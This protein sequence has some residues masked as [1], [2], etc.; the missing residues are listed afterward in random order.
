MAENNDE[1]PTEV[2]A[3]TPRRSSD[4]Y[5]GLLMLVLVAVAA[6]GFGAGLAVGSS[7]GAEPDTFAHELADWS[8]CVAA[9]GAAVPV[10]EAHRDGSFTANFAAGFF[11]EFQFRLLIAAAGACREVMPLEELAE[12][13][14]VPGDVLGIGRR[15]VDREPLPDD[16]LE[17]LERRTEGP[18]LELLGDLPPGQLERLCRGI[19]ESDRPQDGNEDLLRQLQRICARNG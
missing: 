11:E 18:L 4:L 6:A 7:D 3:A 5:F 14:G 12:R 8:A 2:E 19:L 17:Q 1:V 9:E 13:L 15:P 16:L 10:I